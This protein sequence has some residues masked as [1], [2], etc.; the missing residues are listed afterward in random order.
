M[1]SEGRFAFDALRRVRQPANKLMGFPETKQ[2]ARDA[3]ADL[4]HIRNV[5]RWEVLDLE[6]ALL[7]FDEPPVEADLALL[8]EGPAQVIREG[9]ETTLLVRARNVDALLARHPGAR[10]QRELAWIR[11]LAPM[12][13]EVVGFLALVTERLARAGVPLGAVCGYSRDHLFIARPY[14]ARAREVLS[15]LFPVDRKR[16]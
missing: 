12:G 2:G 7:G 9:G 4:E 11:F 5:M 10:V 16:I 15:E 8:G 1:L 6:F 3:S 14:L 13:W